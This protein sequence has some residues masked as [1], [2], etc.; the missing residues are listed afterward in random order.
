MTPKAKDKHRWNHTR[1]LNTPEAPQPKHRCAVCRDTHVCTTCEGT[2]CMSC[3]TPYDGKCRHC[4]GY[5]EDTKWRL[6]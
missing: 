3:R 6:R 5:G 2:G 1:T 4:G